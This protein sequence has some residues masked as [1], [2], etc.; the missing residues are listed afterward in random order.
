M[1]N[2]SGVEQGQPHGES[3]TG[4]QY[5]SGAEE[6]YVQ[7]G[8]EYMGDEE[9]PAHMYGD[10]EHFGEE[11]MHP[12]EEEMY[13]EEEGDH[14]DPMSISKNVNEKEI[15]ERFIHSTLLDSINEYREK[16]GLPRLYE[17][18]SLI[19]HCQKYAEYFVID[20]SD[21]VNPFP[22]LIDDK[23]K[24]TGYNEV[25]NHIYA[26]Y[27]FE[28]NQD[29]TRIGLVSV[30]EEVANLFMECHTDRDV[31]L[32][33]QFNSVSI[34]F[35]INEERMGFVLAFTRMKVGITKIYMTETG[36]SAGFVVKG[37]VILESDLWKVPAAQIIYHDSDKKQ[38]IPPKMIE[39]DPDNGD[40]TIHCN[41][42]EVLTVPKKKIEIYLI[43][44]YTASDIPKLRVNI[45]N[46]F[47]ALEFDCIEYPIMKEGEDEVIR[48]RMAE[49]ARLNKLREEQERREK[50][51]E[52]KRIRDRE[53][54]NTDGS[55]DDA[56]GE[57]EMGEEEQEEQEMS[58]DGN[59]SHESDYDNKPMKET[60]TKQVSNSDIKRELE[61]TINEA[62]RECAEQESIN[63]RLQA[64]IVRL[65]RMNNSYQDR[66]SE[67]NMSQVKYANTL[68]KVH[69]LRLDMRHAHDKYQKST[70]D[71]RAK[72][73]EKLAKCNEI[74]A[75]FMELKREVSKAAVFSRKNTTISD[76]MIQDWEKRENDLSQELQKLRM[77]ILRQKNN[78]QKNQK[79]M[80]DKEELA[81]GLHL[82][83]FEQL[84]IENQ[85][86]NEKI[87]D[88]NEDLH[89][90]KKKN[91]TTVQILK[92]TQEKLDQIQAENK[93]LKEELG[94]YKD[95]I[96]S[97]KGKITDK[98]SDIKA[99]RVKLEE[100]RQKTE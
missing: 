66:A 6:V 54:G 70:N 22:A 87:E 74:R 29:T 72:L 65:R 48:K 14:D 25:F 27:V 53:L 69:Q 91:T 93:K 16:N 76:Q 49:Q 64:E 11:N 19:V 37:K 80:K 38:L 13:G 45:K 12:G 86:L 62:A 98:K 10:E 94:Y 44:G 4:E 26:R 43:K 42:N 52:L 90:L 39:N 1:D 58:D 95:R 28:D 35:S 2:S 9:H 59:K 8:E 20:E 92:H 36:D 40:F 67:F 100:F 57:E 46:Y 78:L 89:K 31:I 24:N 83:D 51:E 77:E 23:V 81:E 61:E 41:I 96:A 84:K 73:T 17:N 79:K 68:A 60:Q 15:T 99:S 82:I 50:A 30:A 97:E 75:S 56:D 32:N 21:E 63:L 3:G 85:S 33:P 5:G 18:L 7:G 71:M 34:G 88:R 47:K 55:P